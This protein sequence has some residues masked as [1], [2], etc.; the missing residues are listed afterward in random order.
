MKRHYKSPAGYEEDIYAIH[1]VFYDKK[2]MPDSWT[3]DSVGIQGETLKELQED[4][5]RFRKA[6]EKP[7][8]DEEELLKELEARRE[9]SWSTRMQ[10]IR[11][12][13][14]RL[15]NTWISL[16]KRFKI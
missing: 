15:K 5:E 11:S 7:I 16:T 6:F 10:S 14:L 3:K 9:K 2:L 1:E 4:F 12:I 8:L 13:G